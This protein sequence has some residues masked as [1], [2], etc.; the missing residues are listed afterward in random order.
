[1]PFSLLRSK[2]GVTSD[3]V[4]EVGGRGGWEI[5]VSELEETRAEKLVVTGDGGTEEP[6]KLIGFLVPPEVVFAV[7]AT[8]SCLKGQPAKLRRSRFFAA[9]NDAAQRHDRLSQRTRL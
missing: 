7:R 3:D 5:G 2:S 1:M 6:K 4:G 9:D 8:W